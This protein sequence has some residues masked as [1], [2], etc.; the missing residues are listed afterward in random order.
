MS[1]GKRTELI[2]RWLQSLVTTVLGRI[3]NFVDQASRRFI[4]YRREVAIASGLALPQAHR[5][6]K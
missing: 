4:T 3:G 5:P 6:E 1:I 2:L